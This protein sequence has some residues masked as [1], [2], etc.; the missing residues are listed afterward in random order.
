MA[1]PTETSTP[2]AFSRRYAVIS[3]VGVLAAAVLLAVLHRQLSIRIV[4]DFGEQANVSVATTAVNAVLPELLTFLR[5]E[6]DG[7]IGADPVGVPPGL[8]S[9]IEASVRDTPIER[10]KIYD[11]EGIVVYSTRAHEIGTNDSANPRFLGSMAGAVRSELRYRD[12]LFDSEPASPHDN[13]IETYVPIRQP[14]QPQPIGVFEIYTDVNPIVQAMTQSELLIDTGIALVMITLYSVLFL[15]VR[16]AERIITKQQQTILERN[17]TLQALSA[18][19]LANEERE[20][21]RVAWELHE[22][23]AQTLAAVKMRVEALARAAGRDRDPSPIDRDGEIVPLVQDAMREIRAL[24]VE[25]R[26]PALDDFGLVATIQSLCREAA[27][28]DGQMRIAADIALTDDE[29]PE[30]LKGIIFRIVQQ[31]LKQLVG[32]TGIGDIRIALV[33]EGGLRLGVDFA[34]L[35]ADTGGDAGPQ[36]PAD[37]H[38]IV[39]LWE[40]AVLSGG[41]FSAT[42]D[43]SGRYAFQVVWAD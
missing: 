10:V 12:R 20:R 6:V 40:S 16:R 43:G 38:P 21:R 25:L 26:P 32:M 28:I 4:S 35:A 23:I 1:A 7:A 31:T 11:G 41:T 3:L 37:Q 30:A 9:L 18:R 24:A 27:Q 29:I 15:V 33:R 17:Q 42:R 22:E 8:A 13:P 5:T 2:L 34:A 19:M 14:A 39:P 36:P